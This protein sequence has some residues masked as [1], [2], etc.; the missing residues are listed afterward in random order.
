MNDDGVKLFFCRFILFFVSQ[1]LTISLTKFDFLSL[2]VVGRSLSMRGDESRLP[3]LY[4]QR[5]KN[6][7][8]KLS[9]LLQPTVLC[10]I[11][12]LSLPL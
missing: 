2:V 6:G 9:K 7:F 11:S 3:F 12:T 5:E 10:L 8:L 1:T 4:V